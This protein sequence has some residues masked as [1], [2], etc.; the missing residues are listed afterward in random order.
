MS[1]PDVSRGRLSLHRDHHCMVGV[2]RSVGLV[3]LVLVVATL[4][5]ARADAPSPFD[6][7]T[8]PAAQVPSSAT[9]E[10]APA[11]AETV[12]VM[13]DPGG[14][15]RPRIAIAGDDYLATMRPRTDI[16]EAMRMLSTCVAVALTFSAAAVHGAPVVLDGPSPDAVLQGDVA[17]WLDAKLYVE[18]EDK[19]PSVR[20]AVLGQP[21]EDSVGAVYM[22]H[23]RGTQGDFIDVELSKSDTCSLI[24]AGSSS[25]SRIGQIRLFVHRADLAPVVTKPFSAKFPDGTSIALSPG[26]PVVPVANGYRVS[27][28]WNTATF[29]IPASSIG[30]AYTYAQT[31]PG[32]FSPPSGQ[33]S[34]L[35]AKSTVTVG[36]RSFTVAGNI[37]APSSKRRGGR[38]L[39][40]ISAPCASITVSAPRGRVTAI[41]PGE[42]GGVEGGNAEVTGSYIPASTP[43]LTKSGRTIAVLTRDVPAPP[44]QP[45]TK[46]ATV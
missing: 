16:V 37:Y 11:P 43:L 35:L 12:V 28:Q 1:W 10:P 5:V 32:V 3:S 21:R 23:V 27:L 44:A 26:V 8:V 24:G 19:A 2:K 41:E 34:Y 15:F 46:P 29:A 6:V 40:P 30:H 25:D 20:L 7:R 18:A 13:A 4:S 17:I 22:A 36:K 33:T 9:P 45:G 42:E 14:R 39:V 31:S 38:A